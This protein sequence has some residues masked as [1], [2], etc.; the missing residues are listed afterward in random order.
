MRELRSSYFYLKG[1]EQ[2][3]PLSFARE[4]VDE[5][6][7]RRRVKVIRNGGGDP[8]HLYLGGGKGRI[9]LR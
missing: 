1:K 2:R 7:V 4:T 5:T 9:A 3:P 8:A 6:R